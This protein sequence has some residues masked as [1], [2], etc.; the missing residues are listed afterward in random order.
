MTKKIT[1]EPHK[2]EE[3]KEILP[4]IKTPLV[5]ISHET[6]DA[7]I[8]EEFGNL[9]KSASAGALK[10]FRSSDKKP[11]QGIEYGSE[12][13]PAIMEK[14]DEA[15][16]VVCLLT[17]HSVDRP[18]ILYEA[19]VAKGKLNT[20]V[21]GVALGIPLSVAIKG[22]FAQF[23]NLD[24]DVPSL[25]KLILELV[26]KVPGLDPDE[27]I[28]KTLVE[29]FKKKSTEIIAKNSKTIAAVEKKDNVA[30]TSVAKLFEEVK[31]MF[32]DLPSRIENRVDPEYRRRKM[33]F[34]P[35]MMD[36][37]LHMSGGV[38]SQSHIPILMVLSIYKN[39]FPW[40]YEIG[41]ETLKIL[42]SKEP[43]EQ[44]EIAVKEFLEIFELT[45]KHPMIRDTMSS[46]E[47]NM[48]F[49]ETQHILEKYFNRY[50]LGAKEFRK[51]KH[52]NN[53]SLKPP[54]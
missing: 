5:F 26:K 24:D 4:K 46:N 11:T 50:I 47:A 49:R 20:K 22:P 21:I 17:Q 19:G 48:M 45:F 2:K 10:S 8:A 32:E 52:R 14:I 44:K 23:Q 1:P 36:D 33:R 29:T 9:L 38:N 3:A 7:E 15:T 35:M 42:Q 6:R 13:Y 39:E 31:I 16:D 41:S 40:I 34:N 54:Y 37:I 12:W 28:V 51:L 27:Q 43:S 53:P 25:T 18:W 30:E